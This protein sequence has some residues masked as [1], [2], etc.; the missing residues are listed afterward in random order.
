MRLGKSRA[1]RICAKQYIFNKQQNMPEA[2][3]TLNTQPS[4]LC[5]LAATL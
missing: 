2:A 3:G 1:G 4:K 5:S